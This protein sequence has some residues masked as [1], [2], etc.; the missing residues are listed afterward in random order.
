MARRFPT[1]GLCKD[2]VYAIKNAA[3]I[4]GVSE[5]TFRKWPKDGLRLIT[6]QRPYLV[7]GAD[8][9]EFMQKRAAANKAPTEKGQFYCMTCKVPRNPRDGTLTYKATTALTG[10]ISGICDACGGK[11]GQFCSANEAGDF[12][13]LTAVPPKA[14]SHA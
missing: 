2:R 9:I 5:A 14:G 10:R 6:D 4:I 13:D 12:I 8:L 11:V 1:R 3:R 7:R